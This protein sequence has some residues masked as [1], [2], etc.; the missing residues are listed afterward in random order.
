M[1]SQAISNLQGLQNT[2][3]QLQ[4]IADSV[5]RNRDRQVG[6]ERQ[7]TDLVAPDGL[8]PLT[9]TAAAPTGA[10][11]EGAGLPLAEQLQQARE[12]LTLLEG[13][14][15][16]DAAKLDQVAKLLGELRDAWDQ[17]A[18]QTCTP[19]TAAS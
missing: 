1:P 2:R 4:S 19:A 9:P 17:A 18:S 10:P 6:L 15:K 7:I 8:T 14:L 3:M 5:H 11:G 12:R 16:Q 13:R